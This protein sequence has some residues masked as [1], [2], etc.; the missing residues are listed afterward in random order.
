MKVKVKFRDTEF[1]LFEPSFT[2][3][4]LGTAERFRGIYLDFEA[5]GVPWSQLVLD[6]SIR[7]YEMLED[8]RDENPVFAKATDGVYWLIERILDSECEC[9]EEIEIEYEGEDMKEKTTNIDIEIPADAKT[10]TL[11]LKKQCGFTLRSLLPQIEGEVELVIEDAFEHGRDCDQYRLKA[12]YGGGLLH[13][14][15]R[16]RVVDGEALLGLTPSVK[17][18]EPQTSLMNGTF[19]TLTGTGYIQL[20]VRPPVPE[21]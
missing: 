1:G 4:V 3:P 5:N 16:S 19:A 11:E 12:S 7:R 20:T 14:L 6:Q 9:G 18:V 17:L 13:R 8:T 15:A 2:V 10:V 21:D